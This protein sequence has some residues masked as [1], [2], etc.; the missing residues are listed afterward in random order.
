MNGAEN[1]QCYRSGARQA[2]D[3][4]DEQWAQRMEHSQ[5]CE[6]IAE[7][8]GRGKFIGVMFSG[9]SVGMPVVVHVVIVL[10]EM[11]VLA[12]NVGMRR[13]EFLAEPFGNTRKIQDAQQDEHQS[14]GKFHGQAEREGESQD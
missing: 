9:S 7:P 3:D 4:A 14:H 6:G 2:V 10:V 12:G 1:Q 11:G 5:V 8:F 13:R